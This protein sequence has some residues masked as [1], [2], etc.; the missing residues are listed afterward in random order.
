M[1]LDIIYLLILAIAIYSGLRRGLVVAVF[2]ALA[3]VAGLAAAMKLSVLVAGYLKSHMGIPGKWLPLIS[4]VLVFL[5]VA[6]LVRWAA[7][8][9]EALVD[10]AWLGW[11]NKLGAVFLYAALYTAI[12]SVALFYGTKS[13]L[14]S[15]HTFSSSATYGF[16][17]PWGPWVIDGLGKLIPWFKNMFTELEDFFDSISKKLSG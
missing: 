5:A 15:P 4:F 1:T 16:V 6:L 17:K 8:L 13:N 11:A 2:S 10:M 12:F 14:I 7:S 9:L 3:L